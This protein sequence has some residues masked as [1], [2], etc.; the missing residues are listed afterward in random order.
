MIRVGEETGQLQEMLIQVADTY[1][2]EV[3]TAV[4]RLLTL[5]EPALI[6]GLGVIIAGIIMSI[7]VAILSLN[8][9]LSKI[10][11]CG[12]QGM[13]T[14]LR[15]TLALAPRFLNFLVTVIDENPTDRSPLARFYLDRI[16]GGAGD[17]RLAGGLGRAAGHEVS[18]RRQH[19]TAKLQIED[20]ST[21]LDAFRLDMGRYP[22]TAE[23]LQA[24][25]AAAG[26]REPLERS[27]FAQEPHPQGPLGQRLSISLARPAQRG[28]VRF[29]LA[30][31]RQR[32]GRR[33]R[34]S[35]CGELAVR[36]RVAGWHDGASRAAGFY[37]AGIL[38]VVLVIAVL[39]VA[40]CRRCCPA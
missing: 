17:S 15:S 9:W 20:F 2:G 6:L 26:G 38:M 11:W 27:L 30:G 13:G 23:G 37:P 33:R 19:Q 34:K 1:D 3:Q 32:R 22:T 39:L 4:K 28:R 36:A 40:W 5:L 8:D 16:V 29:V 18:G 7:L 10:Q 14:A 35:G 12:K 21:A 25:V 24:L 31:G